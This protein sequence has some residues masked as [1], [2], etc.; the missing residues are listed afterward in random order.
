VRISVGGTPLTAGHPPPESHAI[1]SG[2]G[3]FRF[4]VV[5]ESHYQAELERIVGWRTEEGGNYPCVAIVSP[6]PEN[7]YDPQAVCV[8]V[9]DLKVAYLSRDWAPKL[10]AALAL[11]GYTQATCNAV[12]GGGWDRGGNDR[13]HFGIK[14]DMALPFHL[15]SKL[16][17][18]AST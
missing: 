11:S 10:N 14:L 15:E 7:E 8:R 3:E 16:R 2:N 9:N 13:G 1:R 17:G 6:E 12:I 18:P 5:G 4:E